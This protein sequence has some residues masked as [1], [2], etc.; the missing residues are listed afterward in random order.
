MQNCCAG[1]GGGLGQPSRCS[2]GRQ[3]IYQPAHQ[4]DVC[5]QSRVPVALQPPQRRSLGPPSCSRSKAAKA[6]QQAHAAW[7]APHLFQE[8]RSSRLRGTPRIGPAR[9]VRKS[10]LM[11]S[12][13]VFEAVSTTYFSV[14]AC[15]N[16][17][18]VARANAIRMLGRATAAC[19]RSGRHAAMVWQPYYAAF[20]ITVS[21]VEVAQ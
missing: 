9:A 19:L 17:S 10:S 2:W 16:T 21:V 6:A 7:F 18:Q 8:T 15:D 14:V 3:A 13:S 5:T 4:A 11:G 1:P 20:P 12:C